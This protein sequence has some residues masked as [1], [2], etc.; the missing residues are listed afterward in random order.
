MSSSVIPSSE[1]RFHNQ[2]VVEDE[3]EDEEILIESMKP[4]VKM[5]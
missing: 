4:R 3:D 2:P 1:F 5:E